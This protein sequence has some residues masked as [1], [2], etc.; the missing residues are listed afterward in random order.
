MTDQRA[1]IE[2]AGLSGT[3]VEV[4]Y[5]ADTITVE[6]DDGSRK[7]LPFELFDSQDVYQ[8]GQHFELRLNHTGEP[9]QVA[10]RT[11]PEALRI[12]VSGYV[13]SVDQDDELVWVYVRT[14]EG[15]QRK[16]MPLSLF[17][18]SDLARPGLHFLLDLDEQGTPL[19]LRPDDVELE[20]LPQS[21]EET[22]PRWTSRP[23]AEAEPGS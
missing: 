17:E 20:M 2:G 11:S 7:V 16:V 1:E 15:W 18:E 6:L 3:V 21:R 9:S 19:R 8:P 5:D 22:K 10:G 13:E 23:A 12:T 4:D 14:E